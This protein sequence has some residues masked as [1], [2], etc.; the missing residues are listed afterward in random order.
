MDVQ[1]LESTPSLSMWLTLRYQTSERNDIRMQYIVLRKKNDCVTR[2]PSQRARILRRPTRLRQ[3]G[4]TRDGIYNSSMNN[5][6]SAVE[7]INEKEDA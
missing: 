5:S 2:I 3:S 6:I 7:P 1:T 4:Q